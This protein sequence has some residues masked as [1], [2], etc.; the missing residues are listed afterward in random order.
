[1][2]MAQAR[3][4]QNHSFGENALLDFSPFFLLS[5]LGFKEY[6]SLRLY[7]LGVF[8][9]KNFLLRTMPSVNFSLE[10]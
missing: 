8:F 6:F 2:K 1:M 5:L 9:H 10:D 7:R 4:I 3:N